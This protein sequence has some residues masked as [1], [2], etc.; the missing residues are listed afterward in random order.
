[1]TMDTNLNIEKR[2]ENK[3]II[4]ERHSERGASLIS[5][6]LFILVLGFLIS[7]FL[8]LQQKQVHLENM[9]ITADRKAAIDTALNTFIARE[10]RLPC[11]ASM[12]ADLDTAA[13]GREVANCDTGLYAMTTAEATAIADGRVVMGV[14]SSDGVNGMRVQSGAIPVRTLNLPDEYIIDAEDKRFT[15][16]VTGNFAVAGA[17]FDTGLGDITLQDQNGN[18]IGSSAGN[19]IYALIA[20]GKSTRGAYAFNGVELDPCGTGG[21]A[22]ANCDWGNDATF[23]DSLY[24]AQDVG[25]NSFTQTVSFKSSQIAMNW[26]TGSWS[27]CSVNC[28]TGIRTR[29]VT[30]EDSGGN[31]VDDSNC[32]GTK[33]SDTENCS[34]LNSCLWD[35]GSWGSC[36]PVCGTPSSAFRSVE[37]KDVNGNLVAESY[38]DNPKPVLEVACSFSPASGAGPDDYN[39]PDE[40][41][42][43]RCVWYAGSWSGCNETCDNLGDAKETRSVDCRRDDNGNTVGDASDSDVND[44]LCTTTPPTTE[45]SCTNGP[46]NWV[47]GGFGECSQECGGGERTQSVTCQDGSGNVVADCFCSGTKPADTQ[48]CNMQSC[49]TYEWRTG[50]YGDCD[51]VCV[52][53]ATEVVSGERTRTVEC[54]SSEGNVV[55]D[56]N[57]TET[58]PQETSTCEVSC[59]CS[60]TEWGPDPAQICSGITFT[61]TSNCVTRRASEGTRACGTCTTTNLGTKHMVF[62]QDLTGSFFDDIDNTRASINN[63]FADSGFDSWFVGHTTFRDREDNSPWPY[64]RSNS[65]FMTVGTAKQQILNIIGNMQAGGG[66]DYPEASLEALSRAIDDFTPQAS[67]KPIT[68][69]LITDATAKEWVTPASV[70]SKLNSNG[71][72]LIVLSTRR[73]DGGTGTPPSS[74]PTPPGGPGGPGGGGSCGDPGGDG[75]SPKFSRDAIN[76]CSLEVNPDRLDDD[77][78][79]MLAEAEK[80][81][82]PAALAEIATS[83]AYPDPYDYYNSFISSQGIDGIVQV[84]SSNSSNL[85]SALMDGISVV[86]CS[87]DPVNGAC[88]YADGRDYS[89]APSGADLCDVGTASSVSG[90]GPWTWTCPGQNGGS[91]DNCSAGKSVTETYSWSTGTYG[92]CSATACGT[93]GEQTRTVECRRDSDNAVVADANCDSS[94]RPSATQACSAPACSYS[95]VEVGDWT[96]C[97]AA[98]NEYGPQ[99]QTVECRRDSDNAVVADSNCTGTKPDTG[100]QCYGGDCGYTYS[101]DE[102]TWDACDAT[103]G[104]GNQTRTVQCLR[105][106]GQVADESACSETKPDTTQQCNT[107]ECDVDGVCGSTHYNCTSGNAINTSNPAAGLYTWT[108]KGSGNGTDAS[109]D[110]APTCFNGSNMDQLCSSDSNC[111]SGEY[112]SAAG[113]CMANPV[114]YSWDTGSWGA[115]DA[116]CGDGQ[117][118]RTVVCKD[119][120]GNT[121]ADSNC[122][123]SK[124]NTTQNCYIEPPEQTETVYYL[125]CGPGDPSNE[126]EACEQELGLS[127]A[128]CAAATYSNFGTGSLAECGSPGS[129]D[130]ETV[131]RFDITFKTCGGASAPPP[132]PAVTPVNGSCGSADGDDYSSAPTSGLC[133]S[134]TPSDVYGSGPWTWTCAGQHGGSDSGTCTANKTAAP[135]A[136]NGVC[137]SAHQQAVSGVPSGSALCSSGLPGSISSTNAGMLGIAYSW[138]CN[139]INGGSSDTDCI[140]TNPSGGGSNCSCS[141]SNYGCPGD[142]RNRMTDVAVMCCHNVDTGQYSEGSCL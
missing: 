57:C 2:C 139:G 84:I 72:K 92:S 5:M 54:Y 127:Q 51:A 78:F 86:S 96:E 69:V 80:V 43:Q 73:N 65:G 32:I 76:L 61:Q 70:A 130:Y 138:D 111:N 21:A 136:E 31:V 46:Y 91:N 132:P 9:D 134:G 109:C 28:S 121:V 16:A 64:Q 39:N 40:R 6:S 140:A 34:N 60:E 124:P 37:C 4:Q 10:G 95:W 14:S 100:R 102:G 59:T 35:V 106:D 62:V 68:F 99:T 50:E 85:E 41:Q 27:G 63:L 126:Y 81:T 49:V 36:S 8:V 24:K 129:G 29:T 97:L 44:G 110:E 88:G 94:T 122:S 98:C 82:D 52:D 103:C 107:Q 83:S 25:D 45:Q 119:D 3:A 117:E 104:G 118:T 23:V 18:E 58:K 74:Y 105:N 67:G 20:P 101:W 56:S 115:C 112:C 125:D 89:A 47:E 42:T 137:G 142:Q 131:E 38:C 71:H 77:Y 120:S 79:T 22:A 7:G 75:G 55:D 13:F 30:C 15:Y 19:V 123:G 87:P 113:C 141:L 90:S 12:T 17:N 133:G 1:M 33:P 53:G 128:E 108:C 135:V 93:N 116:T 66:G 114:T 48:D 11:P 26:V